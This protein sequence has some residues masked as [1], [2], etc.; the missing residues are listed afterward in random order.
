MVA[1]DKTLLVNWV[2]ASEIYRDYWGFEGASNVTWT[3]R[4]VPAI[5]RL[6]LLIPW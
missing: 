3:N 2:H 6:K 4:R 1:A 5:F